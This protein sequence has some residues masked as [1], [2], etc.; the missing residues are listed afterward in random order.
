VKVSGHQEDGR[1][2][3]CGEGGD[4]LLEREAEQAVHIEI[5]RGE[6][7]DGIGY[8][9]SPAQPPW[10]RAMHSSGVAADGETAWCGVMLRRG[11]DREGFS[12]RDG[13]MIAYHGENPEL[14]GVGDGCCPGSGDREVLWLACCA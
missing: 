7:E 4:G 14:L 2:I 8:R 10:L 13:F 11:D 9:I 5:G 1:G 3:G 12:L 6:C